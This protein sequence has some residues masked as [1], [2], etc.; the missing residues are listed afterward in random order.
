MLPKYLDNL[1]RERSST[2]VYWWV[3]SHTAF[4]WKSGIPLCVSNVAS[5]GGCRER[6]GKE[7]QAEGALII[8]TLVSQTLFH[9]AL[10]MGKLLEQVEFYGNTTNRMTDNEISG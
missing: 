10:L 5:T 4:K 8:L 6:D 9:V 1:F 2:T 3:D 7:D